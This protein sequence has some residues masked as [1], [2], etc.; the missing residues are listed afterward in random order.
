MM[1][2]LMNNVNELVSQERLMNNVNE[3]VSQELKMANT[4]FPPFN[5]RHEGYAVLLEEVEEAEYEMCMVK[6]SLNYV[7]GAV[8][9][10]IPIIPVEDVKNYA[11]RLACEAIQVAA[12]CDKFIDFKNSK[13]TK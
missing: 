8:K 10:D 11:V 3:L 1:K 9:T 4:N 2:R 7:W 12:M 6:S 13:E 5:S